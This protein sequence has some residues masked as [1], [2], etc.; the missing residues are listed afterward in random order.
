MLPTQQPNRILIHK[1]PDLRLVIA[2]QVVMQPGFFIIILVLQSERLMRVLVNPARPFSDDPRRCI[3]R[4]IRDCRGCRSSRAGCRFGRCGNRRGIVCRLWHCQRLA[5]A[6][7][8]CPSRCRDGCGCLGRYTPAPV[9]Y[10]PRRNG[11]A[12]VRCWSRPVCLCVL[13]RVF[14]RTGRRRIPR[15]RCC[16]LSF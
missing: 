3:R 13:W 7:R 11:S 8:S 5:P 10:R 1:P 6:V 15:F 4:T 9:S 12:L 2:H 14:A 16:R